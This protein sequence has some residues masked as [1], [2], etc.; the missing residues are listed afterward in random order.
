V[1]AVPARLLTVTLS[2]PA[3]ASMERRSTA[4]L[5]TVVAPTTMLAP[6]AA[7]ARL[8]AG[9]CV[10]LSGA[11]KATRP[12]VTLKLMT[13]SPVLAAM[14]SASLPAPPST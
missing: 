8:V 12:V 2:S 9:D 10:V 14:I 7:R 3:M 1:T 4:V 6:V 13:L 5:V 11:V